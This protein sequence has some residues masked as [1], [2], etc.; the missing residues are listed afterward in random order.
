MALNRSDVAE[1]RKWDLSGLFASEE[2]FESLFS[3][4]E[5]EIEEFAPLNRKFT[6][7]NTLEVLKKESSLIRKIER[8]YL[9]SH[10]KK[11]ENTA[12]AKYQALQ[13]RCQSL[14]TK[15]SMATAFVSPQLAK[16]SFSD[17]QK[18]K[19]MPEY[20]NFTTLID[21]VIREKKHILSEKEEKII[22]SI[23]D[24]A[25]DFR[26]IFG[27]LDNADL[28]FGSVKNSD[29]EMV[30]LSHGMYSLLLQDASQEV[31]A[32]AFKTYYESYI[33]MINTIAATYAGSVKKD[34]VLS[35]L[36]G[37]KSAL[38]KALERDSVPTKVYNNLI[39]AVRKGT[40]SVH[41]Y[42]AFRKKA[43]KLKELH[44]YDMYVALTGEYKLSLGYDEAY[45][46]VMK[47][48]APLGEEYVALLKKGYNE[49]WIDVEETKNKRSGA[50]SSGCYDSNPFVLLNYQPTTHD[51]FTIAHEMGHSIHTYMSNTH[52]CYEKADYTI[53]VAEVASTVNEVLLLKYLLKDAK[54][55]ERKFLLAYYLDM[56]RT[57]LF[58]QTMFAEFEK[59]SHEEYEQGRP[60]TAESMNT[61]YLELNKA[62]YGDAVIHDKEI[63]YEWARIP[64]FYSAFYVYKYATGITSAVS[65]AHKILNE[66]GYVKKYFD[67][68]SA[69]ASLRPLETLKLADVDLTKKEPFDIAIK[70]FNATLKELKSIK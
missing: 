49:R 42:V 25:G 36:R 28:K 50:Y 34:C 23:G 56:F 43:L 57:T 59:F 13:S 6:V 51:V 48:L 27:M 55:E 33:G 3:L 19:A 4:A 31:R 16:L 15:M 32:S 58:R 30:E 60:L 41:K 18:M 52:Q 63:Q 64:H 61:K 37:Y 21:E 38:D 12:A 9:Y 14:I 7:E 20:A 46:L 69:G 35:S 26:T 47:A 65:I 24:F 2:E 17:L 39:S 44:M 11:D 66:E 22:S 5:K 1:N 70:E 54:G 68:L 45:E 10:L 53:F 29:G 67:F 40:P 62:Y 8:L